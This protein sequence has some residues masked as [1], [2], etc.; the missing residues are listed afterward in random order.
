MHLNRVDTKMFHIYAKICAGYERLFLSVFNL[1]AFAL[2]FSRKDKNENRENSRDVHKISYFRPKCDVKA[3]RNTSI[4][5]NFFFN[6]TIM[7]G[8]L[9]DIHLF[10]K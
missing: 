10:Y 7:S 9:I 2:G 6:K 8:H 3:I 4:F 1:S 5:C